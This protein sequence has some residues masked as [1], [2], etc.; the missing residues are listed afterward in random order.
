MNDKEK[1]ATH[2]MAMSAQYVAQTLHGANC[3]QWLSMVASKNDVQTLGHFNISNGG[4]LLL[5]GLEYVAGLP[6]TD[7][8]KCAAW[9][10]VA[11]KMVHMWKT[12]LA[13]EGI[14]EKVETH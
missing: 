2:A 3:T 12:E 14:G 9:K 4:N 5:E 10:R 6:D 13:A 8:P 11:I 1:A 7:C